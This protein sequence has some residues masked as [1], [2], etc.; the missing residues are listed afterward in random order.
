MPGTE[1]SQEQAFHEFLLNQNMIKYETYGNG[2]NYNLVKYVSR[3]ATLSLV[4]HE[5]DQVAL[6]TCRFLDQDAWGGTQESTGLTR[7]PGNSA[8]GG[9]VP[10]Q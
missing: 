4:E 1:S 7:F 10:T 8:A 9:L 5:A 3:E 6:S 2:R